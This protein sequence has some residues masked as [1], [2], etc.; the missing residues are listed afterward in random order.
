[1]HAVA[2]SALTQTLVYASGIFAAVA[3]ASGKPASS[4]PPAR[5]APDRSLSMLA[6][7]RVAV[8]PAQALRRDDP[9]GWGAK[10]SQPREVLSSL[11]DEIAFALGERGL[12][13]AWR[14]AAAIARAARSNPT[15]AADP[16]A[17]ATVSLRVTERNPDAFI[18]D[19]LASQLRTIAGLTDARHVLLP[20]EL[21]F[22]SQGSGGRAVLVVV[23]VDARRSHVLWRGEVKS[24]VATTYSPALVAGVASRLADLIVAR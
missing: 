18:P 24:E 21:L 15:Y 20:L 2:R 13:D 1:M 9:M 6:A 22:E 14:F 23:V 16:Y 3:C 12:R 10:L 8:V 17:L 4:A 7:E 19:P 5:S 11:D